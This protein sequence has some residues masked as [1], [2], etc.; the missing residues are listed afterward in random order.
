[1]VRLSDRD[2]RMT[3]LAFPRGRWR[4]RMLERESLSAS[5]LRGG[6]WRLKVAGS[7]ERTYTLR[8]SLT[9]LERPFRPCGVSLDG[10]ALSRGAW[11]WRPRTRVITARF[12]ARRAVLLV[13]PCRKRR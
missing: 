2:D 13:T 9:A 1:V 6:G 12:A 4:G 11:S 7:R 10:R 8:A 3:L 5:E